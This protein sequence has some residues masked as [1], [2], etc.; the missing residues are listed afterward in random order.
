MK[1]KNVLLLTGLAVGGYLAYKTLMS[2]TFSSFVASV[3]VIG[4]FTKREGTL[5]DD[6]LDSE[7]DYEES[8]IS[9]MNYA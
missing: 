2:N 4:D 7:L 3:P 6:F 5:L 9:Q 1:S 8:Q